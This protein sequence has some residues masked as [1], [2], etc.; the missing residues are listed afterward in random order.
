MERPLDWKEMREA[1]RW[2]ACA[3][4]CM[5]VRILGELVLDEGL[6]MGDEEDDQGVMVDD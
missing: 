3:E 6:M 2:K 5:N 1:S 4:G